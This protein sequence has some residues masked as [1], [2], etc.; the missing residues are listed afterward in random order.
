MSEIA[1]HTKR[2]V[3]NCRKTMSIDGAALAEALELDQLEIATELCHADLE[4]YKEAIAKGGS[5]QIACTQEAP[6]FREVAENAAEQNTQLCFTN[7][8]ETAGWCRNSDG[9]KPETTAKMA[10]LLAAAIYDGTPTGLK[11]ITSHGSCLIYGTGQTTLDAAAKLSETLAVTVVLKDAGDALPP[12][13][14]NYAVATGQVTTLKG[15]LGAFEATISNYAAAQPSSRSA[16]AFKSPTPSV[17]LNFDLVLDLSGENAMLTG[18]DRRDGYFH[19]D[20]QSPI[21][22][23]EALQKAPSLVGEFEKPIYVNF[24]ADICAHS[25]NTKIGCQNCLD[26]CPLGAITSAGDHVKIDAA[27]CSGCGSCSAV[28]PTGAINYAYP[29]RDDFLT[30]IEILARTYQN[31]GGQHPVLLIHDNTFGAEIIDAIARFGDGLPTNTLPFELHTPFLCGHE[32]LIGALIS[33][34]ENIVVLVSPKHPGERIALDEQINLTHTILNALGF[35]GPRISVVSDQDP[36]TLSEHLTTLPRQAPIATQTLAA[37]G[38]KREVSR[39]LMSKLHAVAPAPAETI[40][41]PENAPYGRILIDQDRCTLC[42]ACVSTCPANA[43]SD[44]PD[45]PE[46]SLTEAA[47]VQ[48]GLCRVTCPEKAITL[49]ARYTFSTKA[50]SPEVLNSEEPFCCIR[51][52]TAFGTKSSINEVIDRLKGHAMFRNEAQL[53]LIQMCDR[54]RIEA[55]TEQSDDPHSSGQRPKVRTTDDYLTEDD[56]GREK[57]NP[58][59]D[60]FLN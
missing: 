30:R 17:V 9:Q 31:A 25:R 16:F 12:R 52:G 55:M 6:L 4:V 51:C 49:E 34:F 13:V 35:A 59:R 20:P 8:R 42:L 11:T 39:Q 60:D 15:H 1:K 53:E 36:D 44:N 40:A 43:L 32:T 58:K 33:G 22:V 27:I 46:V 38:N 29:R 48:C 24:N 26:V 56:E 41:L 14:K 3:C 10:A 28:C 7:I 5:V 21:A 54:C 23:S 50:L 57:E 37:T 45:R 18:H 47:C 2:L 19:V